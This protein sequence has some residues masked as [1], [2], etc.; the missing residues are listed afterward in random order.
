MIFQNKLFDSTKRQADLFY[1]EGD[2][3]IELFKA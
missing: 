3:N 2:R 1:N